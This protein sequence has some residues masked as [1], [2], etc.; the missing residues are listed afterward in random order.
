MPKRHNNLPKSITLTKDRYTVRIYSKKDKILHTVGT[1]GT[2]DE[3]VKKRDEWLVT[4]YQKVEGYLPRGITK[5]SSRGT[6]EAQVSLKKVKNKTGAYVKHLGS[7]KTIQEAIDFRKE[8]ILGL[9]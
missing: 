9:L 6:Y 2:L 4:N 7:F 8:F 1:F 5:N 3:A